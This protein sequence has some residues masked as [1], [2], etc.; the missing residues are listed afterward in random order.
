MG[1]AHKVVVVAAVGLLLFAEACSPHA[2]KVAPSQ[3]GR[4]TMFGLPTTVEFTAAAGDVRDAIAVVLAD[5]DLEVRW[6]NLT[7]VDGE[8]IFRSARQQKMKITYQALPST[9]T[10][11]EIYAV[12][13][14]RTL[15]Q[16]VLA[17]LERK[18]GVAA[19]H[20]SRTPYQSRHP[21]V[22]SRLPSV[23]SAS[24]PL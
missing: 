11:V 20:V 4:K 2:S 16:L 14:E 12:T 15:E 21:A 9:S 7:A 17:A 3:W 19:T 5:M 10:R 22:A 24:M 18:L 6:S 13:D 23:R 1:Q 8:Y